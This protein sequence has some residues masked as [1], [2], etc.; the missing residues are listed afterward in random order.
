MRAVAFDLGDTLV[1]YEGLPLSWEAHYPDALAKL[2]DYL[3][4]AP[5]TE[6]IARACAVLRRYNTRLN[7]RTA[8]ATFSTILDDL[9][10]SFAHDAAVEEIAAAMAF[11][12]VFR[13]RLRGF[14]DVR[15]VLE[16]LRNDGIKIAVFTDV[17]Y[18]M[19]REL[20]LDDVRQTSLSD[21]FNVF[22]TSRD[23]GWRKPSPR[24]LQAVGE[25]LGCTPNEMS[26]IGNERKD[27]EAALAYGCRA[28]LLHRTGVRPNWG[29][30]ISITSLT[31]L[32]TALTG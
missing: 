27:I 19:P 24:T 26:Y 4:I 2:A 29:Q 23:V 17:P 31:E 14:P 6:Q 28:I 12:D 5:T 30:H 1:E 7:P 21:L 22:V 16:H 25:Q 8:E 18:G 9:R 15:P 11:F 10:V 32:R 13:Q 3:R 20:V